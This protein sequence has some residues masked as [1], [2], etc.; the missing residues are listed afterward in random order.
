M[1]PKERLQ[2]VLG[3]PDRARGL[4]RGAKTAILFAVLALVVAVVAMLDPRPSLRHVR[5]AM[6]S[7]SP[8]GNYYATVEKL[9]AEVARRRGRVTNVESAGSVE[10]IRR[11]AEA[12]TGCDVEFALVQDGI[13][14]PDK[15]GLVLVGRLPRPEALVVLGRDADRLAG[16][17]DLKGLRIGIGPVGSGTENLMRKVLAPLVAL[18]LKVSTPSI[19]QQLEML[20]RGELD[21][22]AM[23]IDEDAKLLADALRKR[24]LQIY[25]LPGAAALARR[26]PFVHAGS[27]EAGQIDYVRKLPPRPKEVL[28]VQTL[29]VGNGCATHSETQGLMTAVAEILPDFVRHNRGAPN[30]T[31]LPMDPVAKSFFDQEGPD[32][33]GQH[34]PWVVDIMPTATWVQLF[35][36]F[37]V[38][39]SGMSLWHRFRLWRIDANRVKVEREIPA[40]FGEGTTVGDIEAMAASE[41]H[42]SP[43]TRDRLDGIIARLVALSDR[44]RKQSLSVLVPMGEEM[45][46]RYQETLI[47]D[48]LHALRSYR[49]RLS[50][51]AKGSL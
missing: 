42:L 35:V 49:E 45:A 44:C 28:E 22:G 39:F 25:G 13:D 32:L 16:I 46:Y 10:N 21:L 23:V 31:G 3:L 6:L 4:S 19:D 7:G 1:I 41:P 20:E 24:N 12:R 17:D 11:L 15:H 38:L 2:R 26:L 14:W 43:G 37:S 48:T 36:A 29:I 50:T 8:S 34:A 33:V 51:S 9:A 47:A 40:L 5:V 27:I 18:D 30:L